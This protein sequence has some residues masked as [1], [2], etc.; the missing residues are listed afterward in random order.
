MD[1]LDTFLHSFHAAAAPITNQ[2]TLELERCLT[3]SLWHVVRDA[4]GAPEDVPPARALPR[5]RRTPSVRER[6]SKPA[7]ETSST[8]A[9]NPEPAPANTPAPER[10]EVVKVMPFVIPVPVK[11]R[12]TPKRTADEMETLERRI[13]A[14][15]TQSPGQQA[16]AIGSAVGASRAEVMWPLSKLVSTGK[17]VTSLDSTG[18]KSYAPA[19]PP[20]PA[21]TRIIR[22][23]PATANPS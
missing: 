15:V 21:V 10:S 2:L 17:L 8:P 14:H 4:I 23:R 7:Q 13:L 9:A 12:R 3:D 11:R 22:R 1:F 6:A 20:A 18:S 5:K 19:P 16:A